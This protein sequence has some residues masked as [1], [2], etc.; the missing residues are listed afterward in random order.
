MQVLFAWFSIKKD[1]KHANDFIRES[2][3]FNKH[4]KIDNK[5]VFIDHLYNCGI[6]YISD[7]LNQV[8]RILTYKEICKKYECE[9]QPMLYMSLIDAIPLNWRL[10][11]KKNRILPTN[12]HEEAIHIALTKTY[13]PIS[14]T[15][16][17]ELYWLLK[18]GKKEKPTCIQKWLEKKD[19]EFTELQ[20]KRI[21][22]LPL[23]TTL[24]TKLREFQFKIIHRTYASDSLVSLF[25]K[26]VEKNCSK[27]KVKNCL[28]H[29]FA[30]C[31]E[32]KKL[33]T[34]FLTWFNNIL[35]EN[36]D[37]STKEIMFGVINKKKQCLNFCLLHVKWFIHSCRMAAQNP[38]F[39]DFL[40][41]FKSQ[42]Q[43]HKCIATK[44]DNLDSYN[45]IFKKL[46]EA[47]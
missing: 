14:L 27:C 21:F 45:K 46:E 34:H 40:I 7:I 32:T 42:T 35:G 11:I 26:S 38:C 17:K 18:G 8:G 13:K 20:W 19:F 30:E 4:I 44:C 22:T 1:P 25:D 47:L 29:L 37:L 24:N 9:M 23:E 15:K 28:V 36:I 41:Y 43:I 5:V 6:K 2:L 31:K 16:S 33:W 10:E 12:P 3:W 39:L